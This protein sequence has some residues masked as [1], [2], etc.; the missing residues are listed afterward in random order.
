MPAA[1]ATAA[2][3]SARAYTP[4]IAPLLTILPRDPGLPPPEALQAVLV[5]SGNAVDHLP[6]THRRLRL[7]A[8]GDA[9]AARARD[10][11]HTEVLSAAADAARLA[12]LAG[13]TLDPAGR[14]LLL[15]VGEGQGAGLEAALTARGF[16]VLRRAVYTTAA[17]AALPAVA[18]AALVAPGEYFAESFARPLSEGQILRA[19]LFFSA[20]T[21]RVFHRLVEAEGL[22]DRLGALGAL[23]I[24]A[25]TAAELRPLPWREV[26]IAAHPDQ[27]SLLALLP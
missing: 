3:L 12:A 25:A 4:V 1:L 22:S 2:L 13:E 14:P 20:E 18:R 23:A 10:A 26:R 27:A 16:H 15:A 21:A 11:G 5:G 24:S 19:G 6:A 8:V 7:L 9:T 17:V